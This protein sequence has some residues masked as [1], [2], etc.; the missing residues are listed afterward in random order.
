MIQPIAVNSWSD[1][2][3]I[4]TGACCR[5]LFTLLLAVSP[6]AQATA[7][8]LSPEPSAEIYASQI[9][10]LLRTKCV[11]CH[12][13][14]SQEAD[15]R[16]D[17]AQLLRKGGSDGPVLVAGKAAESLL[18]LR[19]SAEDADERMPPEG[20]GEP[21]TAE[22][23]AL[24]TRWINQGAHAP[25]EPIPAD[26][27]RHWAYLPIQ[28][29]TT[30]KVADSMY[31]ENGVDAFLAA[32]HEAIGLQPAAPASSEIV[33]RRLYIDLI[34]LPPTRA[35]LQEFLAD[36]TAGAYRR[37]VDRL[38][39][40]P[41]YGERWGRHWLDVWR[42]SDWTGFGAQI[43]YSQ[44]HVWR[45]RDWVVESLNQDK[46]YNQMLREMLAADELA[47]S[48]EQAL[49]ATGFLARHWYK[50]DR[51]VWLD[52]V[53]EHTGKGFLGM[54]FNCARCHDHK[55]DPITQQEYYRLR[56]VFE[57]YDV[58][59][60]A[61]P[62]QTDADKDGLSR[63]YD[64]RP[65]TP[66]YLFQRGDA[67]QPDKTHPLQPGV[68]SVLGGVLDVRPVPLPL[69]T[70]YPAMREF[71]GR[72][73]IDEAATQL[74]AA[75]NQVGQAEAVL[76]KL[77]ASQH[78]AS[79]EQAHAPEPA[80]KEVSTTAN[81]SEESTALDDAVR[82]VA[83]AA[84]KQIT[85]AARLAAIRARVAAERVKHR[86]VESTDGTTAKVLAASASRAERDAVVADADE[87]LLAARHALQRAREASAKT[88]D[89]KTKQA[90]ATAEKNL[91]AAQKTLK[92]TEQA[93]AKDSATYKPLGPAFPQSS[94]GRRLALADWIVDRQNPLT[95]RVAVN[96]IWLRH[97]GAP[98]VDRVDD[99]GLRSPRPPLADLLDNLA[100]ELMENDWSMKHVHRL[101]VTSRAYRMASFVDP[102]A[103]RSAD[104][105]RDNKLFSRMNRRRMEAEVIRDSLLYVA[106]GLDLTQGGPDIDHKQGFA[107][108]RRSMYFRH[109]RERQ[110]EF[111]RM[112]DAANPREC[113][114]RGESIRPQ[115]AFALVNSS[116]ALQYSRQLARRLGEAVSPG[117]GSK[118]EDGGE[119]FITAAFETVLSRKPTETERAEC[120]QFL[121]LQSQ[122]LG[123]SAQLELLS[124]T[125]NAI[126][127][128]V[129]PAVR[130]REN[131]ILV[132]FNHNDFV[133]IR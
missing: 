44:R 100:V 55:Y 102:R 33:L 11:A 68:P 114:R 49:R 88:K 75:E 126:P 21:L 2:V 47:S 125:R 50:F 73:L 77:A 30:P 104:I 81:T 70:Y 18:V 36:Q 62:G 122:Q 15:L 113:Y 109:A 22:Q 42:Y 72:D 103:N 79:E 5:L 86:A 127:A 14:L 1:G 56:A 120:R 60:D 112:F 6:L 132:L 10:P 64:A 117:P 48:D 53:I 80:A 91:A 66:T 32:Q 51:N 8:D 99:F 115:Q 24:L 89:A 71:V 110:M 54:T 111:L 94:T 98:L 128:S 9:K 35:E 108:P 118:P 121:E 85:A 12:G 97:M 34:G 133:T 61:V 107:V 74:T 13:A 59:V 76:V 17:A 131:L 46:G 20:E 52:S 16:L 130:A 28:R 25:D 84:R 19:V 67:K 82:K 124:D 7:T 69:E 101:I 119:S 40:S 87:K 57:P 93:A 23:I 63:I 41:Q 96:H 45:W 27:T 116:L 123:D 83:V 106:G 58:R 90:V 38:L 129:D 78:V 26:P 105:D 3:K 92:T 31:A 95:A 39:D 43:R 4:R 65:A 37:V 29:P